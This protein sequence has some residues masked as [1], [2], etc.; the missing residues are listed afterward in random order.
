[1][2]HSIQIHLMQQA[3]LV[4]DMRANARKIIH[5]AHA[6]R[7]RGADLVVFPELAL[8]GYPPEDLLLR[9]GFVQLCDAS[10]AMIQQQVQIGRAHV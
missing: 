3:F 5:L 1:M 2:T 4:G 7:D 10:L 6:A 9:P 8:C